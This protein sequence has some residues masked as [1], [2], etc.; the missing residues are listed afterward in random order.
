LTGRP[1][2]IYKRHRDN[3][4]KIGDRMTLDE[5]DWHCFTLSQCDKDTGEWE[6]QKAPVYHSVD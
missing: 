6:L 2:T 3:W 5:N 1:S 4:K